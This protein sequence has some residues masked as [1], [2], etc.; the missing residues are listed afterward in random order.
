[1]RVGDEALRD[2]IDTAIAIRWDDINAV[3]AEFNIPTMPLPKPTLT[4]EVP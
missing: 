2:A 3:L 4:I 1:V